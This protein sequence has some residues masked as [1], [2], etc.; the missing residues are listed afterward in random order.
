MLNFIAYSIFIIPLL[1]KSSQNDLLKKDSGKSPRL[2][3]CS[4][5][6][7]A[8]F[9][10]RFYHGIEMFESVEADRKTRKYCPK[11]DFSCCTSDDLKEGL[12]EFTTG[13]KQLTEH[14]KLVLGIAE[15]LKK[16]GQE[17]LV[18]HLKK[19]S[20]APEEI[21]KEDTENALDSLD[22]ISALTKALNIKIGSYYSGL[23]CSICRPHATPFISK[24]QFTTLLDPMTVIALSRK[25]MPDLY[26]IQLLNLKLTI[27]A[28]KLQKY[29]YLFATTRV[30]K[31]LSARALMDPVQLALQ[32]LR[33]ER[34]FELAVNS[35]NVPHDDCES[36]FARG[37]KLITFEGYES[38]LSFGFIARV[39]LENLTINS[40]VFD[41]VKFDALNL[42]V[43]FFK[44]KSDVLNRWDAN[45]MHTELVNDKDGLDITQFKF[46]PKLWKHA[47][48]IPMA[49]LS[50]VVTMLVWN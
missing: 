29:M 25:V 24:K 22:K 4:S 44:S 33:A 32:V 23:L 17:R 48:A 19:D 39:I 28:Q 5:D 3:K 10:N 37:N 14:Y 12:D 8:H 41:E 46:D 15:S 36:E 18:E 35:P 6:L 45:Q 16:I 20:S 13:T 50:I 1:G 26:A 49:I 30:A 43:N 2:P 40:K 7:L 9:F 34:C 11:L 21:L 42:D 38:I 27:E 47:R 31:F